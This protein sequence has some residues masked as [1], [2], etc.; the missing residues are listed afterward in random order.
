MTPDDTDYTAPDDTIRDANGHAGRL[1][2]PRRA[3][4]RRLPSPN[5][6][7][8]RP[9]LRRHG[10]SDQGRRL[11]RLTARQLRRAPGGRPSW[12]RF[13]VA[14]AFW[15]LT[16]TLAAVGAAG[17]LVHSQAP[18]YKSQAVVAVQ[19]SAVS[20]SSGNPPNM[21]TEEGIAT[22]GTVLARASSVLGV[23]MA[24]LASGLSVSVPGQTTLLHISYSAP[25][26]RVA[27]QRAQAIAEAYVSY[28][29]SRPTAARGTSPATSAASG[30]TPTAVL[31]TPASMPSPAGPKYLIDIVAALIV[32]LALGIGTAW[33][34]DYLDDS[35]R[36][37]RDLEA[38]TAAPV[39][40]LIPAFRAGRRDP[41]GRLAMV[42]YPDSLVVEAYRA[43]RTRLVQAAAL[44]DDKTLLITSP[45]WE[46]KSTVAANLAAALA[47]SGR[48]VVLVIADLRWGR[49][50]ELFGP[51]N[52][53]GLSGLLEGRTNLA[54]AL[55]ATDVPRL[56]LLAPGV[57]PADPAALLQSPAW[58]TA[59]RD[60]RRQA[61]VVVIEAPPILVTPDALPLADLAEMILIVADARRSTRA[62][63]RLTMHEVEHVRGKLAGCV[64]DNVGKRRHLRSRGPG[65]LAGGCA[66]AKS[67]QEPDLAPVQS[68]HDVEQLD[69]VITDLA[70]AI[71]GRGETYAAMG[72]HEEALADFTRAIKLDPSHA[73]VMNGRGET[74]AAMGSGDEALA[75]LTQVID[76]DPNLTWVNGSRSEADEANGRGEEALADY[77]RAI[78]LD[79]NDAR[80]LCSRGRTYRLM[81][82]GEEALADYTRAIDLGLSL[83]WAIGSRGQAYQ[84]MDRGEEALADFTRAI[85][86]DLSLARAIAGRGETH[87]AMGRH[88]EALAD[89]TRAIDLDPGD[90]WAIGSR[91]Q[92][93]QAM[94][95]GEEALADF[96]RAI[97]LDPS[98]AWAIAG[99]GETHAAMGRH[100]EALADFT[101]AIDLDPGDAWAIGSR[102]QVHQAM[103]RHEEALADYTRAID[104]NPNLAWAIAGRGVTFRLMGRHEEALADYT[105]AIDLN[106]NHARAIASRA[107]TYRLMGSYEEALA[108]YTRAIDLDPSYAWA[109]GSR[110]QAYLA[111]G[112]LGEALAD[113]SQAIDLNPS[114]TWALVGRGETYAATGRHDEAL[115]DLTR[116]VD[117]HPGDA[118][119]IGRRGQVYEAMGRREEALADLSQ[120]IDL[121]P[122][123]A[124]AIN[125]RAQ[126]YEAMGRREEA[127]ADLSR[128]TDLTPDLVV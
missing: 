3:R 22:S 116:A 19:P 67:E 70:R 4:L 115:A 37:P 47:Q 123:L 117:L 21:A 80:A 90:A 78:D 71:A 25:V 74:H 57:I 11:A 34:R 59:L 31:V 89:F 83:A 73:G 85:D 36:G 112:R 124:W 52:G 39:L 113:F 94:G 49:A 61:D 24:V 48:S 72:R 46:D 23:P 77:T 88:A 28:R 16:V 54:G 91:G 64:L 63:L 2:W 84:A 97:D 119:A 101:R 62:Q 110:A 41:G 82:R 60:I 15:I 55:Q 38:L 6:Q 7:P 43:L 114:L 86:L 40:A 45:G 9:S 13:L 32:G 107:E 92:A 96:T 1:R 126:V 76:L 33:L 17:A 18:V 58:H 51:G 20:A 127:L 68:E 65:P 118:W 12:S 14:H 29:S 44:G 121:N 93:Y 10:G 81:G 87:A 106:P 103:G 95:R 26:P 102:G 120:A 105:R 125:S 35:L 27:Q 108:D 111:T 30:T 99:R 98:L 79:P 109:I 56:R 42:A 75:D 100:A 122:D 8:K 5:W 128:A 69:N 53:Y 50:Q 66:S 104:L